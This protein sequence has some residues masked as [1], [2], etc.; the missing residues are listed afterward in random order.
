M[1]IKLRQLTVTDTDL[2]EIAVGL[3]ASGW[4]PRE[5]DYSSAAFE[6]W[7][8]DSSHI[9]LVA[10]I[11]GRIAGSS[12]AYMM[13]HPDG[14]TFMFIDEVDTKEEFRRQGVA[15][16]M[17]KWLITYALDNGA[18]EAWLGTEHD[19]PEAKALYESL[20]PDEVEHG[21]IYMFRKKPT[22]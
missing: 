15:T 5:K 8:K 19:N 3:N 4:F 1:P 18:A 22:L 11:D 12:H 9:Y 2:E 20:H 21:P 6:A 7:L 17:M 13:L 14:R 10:H 16:T